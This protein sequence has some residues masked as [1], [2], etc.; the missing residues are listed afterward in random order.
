MITSLV[1]NDKGVLIGNATKNG[2]NEAELYN[3]E[4]LVS[5]VM[6]SG[7]SSVPGGT[8]AT[9]LGHELVH[10]WDRI[11]GTLNTDEWINEDFSGKRIIKAE[12]NATFVENQIR[13]ELHIPLRRYYVY[14]NK[15]NGIFGCIVDSK[16]RAMYFDANAQHTQNYRLISKSKRYVFE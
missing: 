15:G 9:A 3:N 11:Q 16:N 4:N 10:S 13:A 2:E 6:Y 14:D 1:T 12:I 8:S 7:S 5:G